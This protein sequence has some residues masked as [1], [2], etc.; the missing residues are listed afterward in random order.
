MDKFDGWFFWRG[1]CN[2][3]VSR[4][5]FY[6]RTFFTNIAVIKLFMCA[7]AKRLITRML[8]CT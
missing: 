1:N 8:A 6:A 2:G 3:G 7:I 5:F 4:L